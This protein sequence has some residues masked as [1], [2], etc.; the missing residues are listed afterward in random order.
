M[1]SE[2]NCYSSVGAAQC[3]S[4]S[5]AIIDASDPT[6]KQNTQCQKGC[7]NIG[8]QCFLSTQNS[9]LKTA[10]SYPN[11]NGEDIWDGGITDE[12]QCIDKCQQ[13][14]EGCCVDPQAGC[15][16]T[17]KE[18]CSVD[19]G[20]GG[21]TGFYAGT[22][23]S[24]S[25]LACGCT[26]K[27]KKGCLAEKEDVYWFDSCGNPEGVAEDCDYASGTLCKEKQGTATCAT[28]NCE[29]TINVPNNPQDQRNGGLRL[30]GES[31]CSYESGTGGFYDRPGSR[32]YR[33]VCVNGQELVEECKDFRE[34]ICVQ[35]DAD[36]NGKPLSYAQ[37]R[38]I[39]EFPK[40]DLDKY[41]KTN[42]K[43]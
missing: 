6:C 32:H 15:Q 3:A 23:C 8:N 26:G 5:G 29:T 12:Y 10:S 36:A 39:D 1:P 38:S 2:G 21:N 13:K 34:E 22:F 17:T 30:N 4:Q 35:G 33:H 14:E 20:T 37:C 43:F 16:W 9:C 24:N 18:Q 41:R 19:G 25:N 27:F 7:C 11:L 40:I 28:V 31:W 42:S